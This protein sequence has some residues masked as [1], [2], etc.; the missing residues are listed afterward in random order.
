[1][2]EE[3]VSTTDSNKKKSES[4][5]LLMNRL[6][7]LGGTISLILGIIG[8]V[9]PILPTTPFLLIT[10]AAYARSSKKFYNWLLNNRILGMYIRNYRE[11]KGMPIKVKIIT[12]FMLW[13]VILISIFIMINL[14]WVQILLVIIASIVSFHVIMIKPK[15][16]DN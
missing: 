7:F 12:I 6:I 2:T 14:L 3:V 8:I 9:L 4:K 5:R 13:I 10:A 11:G 15:K 16:I 1:M